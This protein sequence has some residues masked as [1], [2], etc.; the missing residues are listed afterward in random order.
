MLTQKCCKVDEL[1]LNRTDLAVF[2]AVIFF[3]VYKSLSLCISGTY[4]VLFF[5][6]LE[7]TLRPRCIKV[8]SHSL[9]KQVSAVA[10]TL[11]LLLAT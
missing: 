9:K 5:D 11:F 4:R 3:L 1:P 8:M 7:K 10:F 2:N 6:G